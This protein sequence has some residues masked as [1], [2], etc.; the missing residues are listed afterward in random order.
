MYEIGRVYIWQNQV[1]GYARINGQETTVTG[2]AR[3]VRGVDGRVFVGQRT[4][5]PGVFYTKG[6]IFAERGDLRPK[7]PP[8]GEKSIS[9]LFKAPSHEPA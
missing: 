6:F 5:T 9:D 4:D 7:N 3:E 2:S 8:S 1:A